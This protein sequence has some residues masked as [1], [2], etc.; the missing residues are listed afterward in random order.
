M[1]THNSLRE[2]TDLFTKLAIPIFFKKFLSSKVLSSI[3]NNMKS[4]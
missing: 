3:L 2:V 4:I 1:R